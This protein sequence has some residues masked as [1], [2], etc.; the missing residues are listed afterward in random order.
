MREVEDRFVGVAKLVR[1]RAPVVDGD[2]VLRIEVERPPEGGQGLD[3]ASR[4]RVHD[5]Q[6][7]VPEGKIGPQFDRPGKVVRRADEIIEFCV[8]CAPVVK[9]IGLADGVEVARRD[10]AALEVQR[11]PVLTHGRRRAGAP[12]IIETVRRRP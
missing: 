8:E 9:R 5:G 11:L 2:G 12:G 7:A 4:E 10:G 1:A 3:V 6:A